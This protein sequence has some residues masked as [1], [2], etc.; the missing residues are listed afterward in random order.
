MRGMRQVVV[1]DRVGFCARD[2][3]RSVQ[4]CLDLE[5]DVW[6][7]RVGAHL[8]RA[9]T[10]IGDLAIAKRLSRVIRR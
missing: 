4:K 1:Q 2:R 5:R 8:V 3:R 6:K 7:P 9:R 10:H